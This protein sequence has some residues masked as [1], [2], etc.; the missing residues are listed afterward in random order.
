MKTL[1]FAS[2]ILCAGLALSACNSNKSGSKNNDSGIGGNTN[3]DTT[4]S[5]K[6]NMVD[7]TIV[8]TTNKGVSTGSGQGMGEGT[9]TN[10]G[11]ASVDTASRK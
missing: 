4:G 11:G 3:M 6:N 8:D 2:L 7:T 1:K 10:V 9:G 5:S